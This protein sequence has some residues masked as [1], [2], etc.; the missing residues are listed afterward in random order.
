MQPKVNPSAARLAPVKASGAGTL[1]AVCTMVGVI[2]MTT[3]MP[4]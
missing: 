4:R 2:R 1:K 3:T